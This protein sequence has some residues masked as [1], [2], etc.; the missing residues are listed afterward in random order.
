MISF[1]IF[2]TQITYWLNRLNIYDGPDE[3]SIKIGEVFGNSK[4]KLMKSISSSGKSMFIDFKKQYE[5][6][7]E[8][9]KFTTLIKYKKINSD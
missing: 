5:W 9:S 3:Q 8:K 6:W 4:H 2:L 7:D 1:V